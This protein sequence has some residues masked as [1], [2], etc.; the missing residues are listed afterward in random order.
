M[1]KGNVSAQ[2]FA[3]F[4]D[5][6]WIENSNLDIYQYTKDFYHVFMD[7]IEKNS[8]YIGLA[9][10]YSDLESNMINGKMSAFL[11]VEDGGF[12]EDKR[13]RLDE[14]YELGLRL[15]T[16]T[17]NYENCIAYPNS[18]NE[19]EMKRGLKPFG[20]DIVDRMNELG[21]IIDVSH[22]SDKGFYDCIKHSSKPI[23]ASH[24][25]ARTITNVPRNMS[26]E[27]IRL[28]AQKGGVMGL[29]FCPHFLSEGSESRIEDILVHI[30]HIIN[31]GGIEILA[32][33]SDFDG[34]EGKL[35]INNI[36]EIGL[37]VQALEKT[38]FS[39]DEIEKI[40]SKNAV[41]I[42]E[43]CLI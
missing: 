23:V 21:M 31:M 1:L 29:N 25:N 43:E 36:G 18:Y 42:V 11:T 16:L 20:F 35:D 33:G 8:K 14:F 4:L 15:I 17:W 34:I 13:E 19:N 2:F 12:L 7:E 5:K 37:L 27:M 39:I 3:L 9:R 6:E 32:L 28:L 30:K 38:G 41:R 26:D 40:C 22:L 10:N 24:S